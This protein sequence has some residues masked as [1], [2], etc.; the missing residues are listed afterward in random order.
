MPKKNMPSVIAKEESNGKSKT[1]F[2]IDK[3]IIGKL[4][5]VN[6]IVGLA[7]LGIAIIFFIYSGFIAKEY[8]D[9]SDV[10]RDFNYS[11]ALTSDVAASAT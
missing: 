2:K 6:T 9:S 1:I 4:L 10:K 8:F 7:T 11:S 5:K 3:K